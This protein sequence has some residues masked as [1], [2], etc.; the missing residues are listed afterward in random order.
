MEIQEIEK[1]VL[2][3]ISLAKI[4]FH[5]ALN[6]HGL[7]I[8]DFTVK[9]HRCLYDTLLELHHTQ[10][11]SEVTNVIEKLKEKNLL[12]HCGGVSAVVSILGTV[13]SPKTL[14]EDI[15]FLKI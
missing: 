5:E 9:T 12:T 8:N 1:R 2:S 14:K 15:S 13:T 3:A 4:F 7:R 11:Q 6:N 10:Q